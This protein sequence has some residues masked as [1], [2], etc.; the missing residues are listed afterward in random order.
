MEGGDEH[1][2]RKADVLVGLF[3]ATI[4]CFAIK[5]DR[6]FAFRRITILRVFR[7]QQFYDLKCKSTAHLIAS[8]QYQVFKDPS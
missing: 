7:L 6:S 2:P 5:T 1:V 3:V 8:L 4:H